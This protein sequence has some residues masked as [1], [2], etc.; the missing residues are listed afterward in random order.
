[1]LYLI[2]I[3]IQRDTRSAS[4]PL[5]F[6]D[7]LLYPT[8][9]LILH[10]IASTRCNLQYGLIERCGTKDVYMVGSADNQVSYSSDSTSS[11]SGRMLTSAAHLEYRDHLGYVYTLY[12]RQ[13][14]IPMK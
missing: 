11:V 12:D 1:M 7:I 13:L 6:L 4:I 2:S 9:Y 14:A 10:Q 5:H 8:L 3:T